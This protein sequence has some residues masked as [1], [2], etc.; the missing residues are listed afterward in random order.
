MPI[1]M[2]ASFLRK[3]P[4]RLLKTERKDD[5]GTH[6]N[7]T[8]LNAVIIGVNLFLKWGAKKVLIRTILVQCFP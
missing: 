8:E 3:K 2:L 6:I 7:L 5:D 4:T 1:R